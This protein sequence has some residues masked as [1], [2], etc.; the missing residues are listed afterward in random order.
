MISVRNDVGTEDIFLTRV[1][2]FSSAHDAA[3]ALWASIHEASKTY[4]GK[5][6]LRTPDDGEQGYLVCWDHGPKQWS[7]AYA[8]SEGASALEFTAISENGIEIRFVDLD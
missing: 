4:G 6:L 8:V 2:H 7:D 1:D 5:A 3:M